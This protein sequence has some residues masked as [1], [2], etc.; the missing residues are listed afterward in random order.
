VHGVLIAEMLLLLA[1]DDSGGV[2]IRRKATFTRRNAFMEVGLSGALLAELT[3]GGHLT[4]QKYG[5]V[6]AGDTRPA[7]ELLAD[8]Y[9]AVRNHLHGRNARG[10]IDGLNRDIGGSWNRVV[11]RLVDV[12]VLDR[13]RPSALRPGRYPVIQVAAQQAVLQQVRTAAAGTGPLRPDVAVVLALA[14]PCR[15]MEE[16]APERRAR[17]QALR[18]MAGAITAAPFA[19]DVATSV[20]ELVAAVAKTIQIKAWGRR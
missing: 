7:D 1:I 3:I 19:P 12:G 14:G 9:G 4:I 6:R 11:N 20:N 15:L 2:P 5:P 18:R 8:V 16:V 10:V 17:T 13:D